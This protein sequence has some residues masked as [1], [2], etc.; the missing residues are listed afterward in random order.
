MRREKTGIIN[1]AGAEN[2]LICPGIWVDIEFQDEPE[3]IAG[4]HKTDE[5]VAE[6]IESFDLKPSLM[7]KTRS[8]GYQAYFLFES[9]F[10]VEDNKSRETLQTLFNDLHSAYKR[11]A[12]S[13][14]WSIN[15][16]PNIDAY[17]EIPQ[18]GMTFIIR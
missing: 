4:P 3:E 13:L 8:G 9:P 16:K 14:G 10:V 2:I 6:F 5:E 11:Q 15:T 7:R 1:L 12:E 18:H 17:L